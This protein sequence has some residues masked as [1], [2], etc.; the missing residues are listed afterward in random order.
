MIERLRA[1]GVIAAKDLR[2]EVA[3]QT[4]LTAAIAF[5]ILVLVVFNFARDPAV[6]TLDMLAPSV[7][8]VTTTFAGVVTLNRSFAMEREGDAIEGL[9]LAPV[10]RSAIF[11]GKYLANLAFVLVVDLVVLPVFVLF[12]NVAPSGGILWIGLLLSLAAAGYVAVGTVLAA[13]TVRTRFAE[14]MLP[15]LLLSFVV[16]PVL[17]GAQ[18]TT[19]LLAG[20][21]PSEIFDWIWFLVIYDIVFMVLGLLLFPVTIDE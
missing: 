18:A 16:P 19:R 5:G 13:M 7:L 10:S 20:R 1:A 11:L 6:V 2:V 21:P 14:L 8:W 9:L 3:S 12:F 4:A 17:V 15:V